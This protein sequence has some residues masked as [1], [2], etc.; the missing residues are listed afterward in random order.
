[1]SEVTTGHAD[2]AGVL[3]VC[4]EG[5]LHPGLANLLKAIIV[6]RSATHSIEIVRD[7]GMVC[8]WHLK[9]IHDHVA[10]IARGRAYAQADLGPAT[11][12]LG[13][14]SNCTNVSRDDI[15]SRIETLG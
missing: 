14:S 2:K 10:G 12:K 9:K 3:L 7:D 15:R 8:F 5:M 13:Q 11:S 1:M 6:A 4:P